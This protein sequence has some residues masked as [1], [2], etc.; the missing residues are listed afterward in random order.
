MLAKKVDNKYKI[1][2]ITYIRNYERANQ[3]FISMSYIYVEYAYISY[4]YI[5]TRDGQAY[6]FLLCLP[7]QALATYATPT[8]PPKQI[9]DPHLPKAGRETQGPALF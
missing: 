5:P 2:I 3:E 9:Q 8:Q 6:R 1:Q 7:I 4:L